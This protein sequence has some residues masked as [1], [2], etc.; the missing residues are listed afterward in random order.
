MFQ[1]GATYDR[2]EIHGAVGGDLQSYLPHL[3]GR[4]VA[5]CLTLDENPDAPRVILPG[6]GVEIERWAKVLVGD[7]SAVPTFIKRA[8]ARWEYVGEYMAARL[9]RD[10]HEI[11]SQQRRTGRRD[12]TCVV[13]MTAP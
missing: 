8:P 5:A 2:R 10:P 13:H 3:G 7:R 12:I 9:S 4:V 11:A 6:T 1:L